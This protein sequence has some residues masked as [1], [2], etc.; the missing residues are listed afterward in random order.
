MAAQFKI[1]SCCVLF[2]FWAITSQADRL[3]VGRFSTSSLDGWQDKVFSR[4]TSYQLLQLK[5]KTVLAAQSQNSASGLIKK[6]HVD[7]KAYPYL[8]W[9]WRIENR[10]ALENE[11]IKAGDDYAARIYVVV[12]GG[13]LPWR[14]RAV[15]YVWANGAPKGEV[16]ENA[17]AG[18]NVLM[19]ALRSRQDKIST[20]YAEK[21]N[22]YEDLKRLFATE[23]RFIDAIALM[24][25][26]DNSHGQVKAYYG[27]IYFS[28]K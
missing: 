22:L 2:S 20:W 12:D 7:I 24:T 5:D 28:Q 8:N 3:P 19:M 26:T 1:L 6:V 23:F 18:N 4:P 17:F 10:L 21:R 16:W 15:N 27:D 14:T 11:K 13:I 25:D 9:S